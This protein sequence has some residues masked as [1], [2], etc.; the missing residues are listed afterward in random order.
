[1]YRFVFHSQK[2]KTNIRTSQNT[3]LKP[4]AICCSCA[5][6]FLVYMRQASKKQKQFPIL[7]IYKMSTLKLSSFQHVMFWAPSY[8]PNQ[9][10][11]FTVLHQGTTCVGRTCI[12]YIIWFLH[13]LRL[14]ISR[15]YEILIAAHFARTPFAKQEHS[16]QQEHVRL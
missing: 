3:D 15:L 11:L 1:M 4:H 5:Q 8:T 7:L 13:F 9:K 12:T 10:P 16:I 2:H 6:Y 14:G